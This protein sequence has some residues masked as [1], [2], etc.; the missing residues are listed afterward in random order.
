MRPC[1][2]LCVMVLILSGC[3][4]AHS[5]MP[6]P[7]AYLR[8]NTILVGDRYV[9]TTNVDEY[10]YVEIYMPHGLRQQEYSDL[11]IK[12]IGGIAQGH[13]ELPYR[14]I[15]SPNDCNGGVCKRTHF[16]IYLPK[17]I[18]LTKPHEVF[19]DNYPTE[20]GETFRYRSIP[21]GSDYTTSLEAK[22]AFCGNSLALTV[23]FEPDASKTPLR[24]LTPFDREVLARYIVARLNRLYDWVSGLPDSQLTQIEYRVRPLKSLIRPPIGVKYTEPQPGDF[25]LA[26]GTRWEPSES[27]LPRLTVKS[28]RPPPNRTKAMTV[29]DMFLLSCIPTVQSL[30]FEDFN[31]KL[32][33][34]IDPPREL[35]R[36]LK[37]TGIVGLTVAASPG[38]ASTTEKVGERTIELDLDVAFSLVSSVAEV[39]K[40]NPDPAITTPIKARERTTRGTLDLRVNPFGTRSWIKDVEVHDDRTSADYWGLTPLFIDSKVST[41]KITKD[42]L[43]L[44]RVVI[45]TQAEYRLIYSNDTFPTYYR[46]IG[47]FSNASDRDFKQLEYKGT[48]E[49]RPVFGKLNHPL[50]SIQA[51]QPRVL[52][53]PDDDPNVYVNFTKGG[54]EIIPIFGGELGRTWSRRNPAEAIQPTDAVKRLYGGIEITLTPLSRTKVTLFDTFYYNFGN[55]TKRRA[56]YFKGM[57]EFLLGRFGDSTRAAHSIFV[58]FEKGHQ[59]PFKDSGVNVVKIGYRVVGD[60][61]FFLSTAR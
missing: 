31:A 26:D 47:R 33:M 58:S 53:N 9:E 59:P 41:G 44:N 11:G 57:G 5:Q 54:F 24:V 23:Q 1:R 42:T 7:E 46:F 22:N 17:T 52:G 8:V 28:L 32:S 48:F 34:S 49:F 60:R 13:Q 27:D 45:G 10:Y 40:K 55:V 50:A 3:Y 2:L 43:S 20:T 29:R 30:P 15:A 12:K 14:L 16:R 36:P 37:K 39:E 35:A 51:A 4:A 56:N 6:D 38:Q 61:M 19:F 18:D 25:I 21:V